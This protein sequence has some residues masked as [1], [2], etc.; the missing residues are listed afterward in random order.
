MALHRGWLI[1]QDDDNEVHIIELT[2]HVDEKD[3][4]Y[5]ASETMDMAGGDYRDGIFM[6]D[7]QCRKFAN[8][9]ADKINHVPEPF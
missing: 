6:T 5:Q 2:S 8:D 4:E 1:A 7:N 3:V 9:L